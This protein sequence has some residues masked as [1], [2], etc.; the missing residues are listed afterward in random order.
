MNFIQTDIKGLLVI[1]PDVW[2]DNRGYFYESYQA[3]RY[4]TAGIKCDFVQ[5]NEAYSGRGVLR[6]LHYQLPPYGQAKLVRIVHGTVLDI[7]VDIRP[8]SP[9]FGKY[10]SVLLSG[11]NKKQFFIPQGFAHGYLCLSDEVIF[12]YKCSN[13]YSKEHEG[14]IRYDDQVLQLDWQ[15]DGINAIVSDRDLNLPPFGQHRKWPA[16]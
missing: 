2:K 8:E 13:F 16:K 7:A 4:Q 10:H 3:E 5:D 14:G 15:L 6:G 1:E 12:S 11:D 9:T